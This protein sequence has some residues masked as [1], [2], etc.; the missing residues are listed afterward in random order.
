MTGICDRIKSEEKAAPADNADALRASL[1]KL[2]IR[3]EHHRFL[4]NRMGSSGSTWL[5]KLLN[6]HPDV[7]CYHEG[8]LAQIY[9]QKSYTSEHVVNFIRSLAWDDMHGAY[10]AIGDVGSSWLG[11]IHAVPRNLFTTGILLRHP[12]RM[13][14]TRLKVFE[15][16]KSFTKID[17]STLRQTEERWGIKACNEMDQIFVQDLFHIVMQ[18]RAVDTVDVVIQLERMND[19]EYCCNILQQLTGIHHE[20]SVVDLFIHNPVNRRTNTVSLQAVLQEFSSEQR[21]WYNAMLKEDL[22]R[23]GY[24]LDSDELLETPTRPPSADGVP[25]SALPKEFRGYELQMLKQAVLERDCEIGRLRGEINDLRAV[26][27]ELQGVLAGVQNS[28]GW[29]LL[30][31]LRRVRKRVLPTGRVPIAQSVE[32]PRSRTKL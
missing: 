21:A 22:P 3:G 7:F 23:C 15:K 26:V 9:P 13:L 11:H 29:R 28:V 16:D 1:S 4:V 8:V 10:K 17:P 14:N 25:R 32:G 24:A 6:S 19:V 31:I 12:A 27:K 30:E 20:P 18:I 2:D 5:V